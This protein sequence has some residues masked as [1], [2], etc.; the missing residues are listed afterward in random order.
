MLVSS[1]A[2]G[3]A[4]QCGM[5]GMIQDD[6]GTQ[7]IG[8]FDDTMDF[9]L[10][11]S[12]SSCEVMEVPIAVW[13]VVPRKRYTKVFLDLEHPDFDDAAYLIRYPTGAWNIVKER[14]YKQKSM[15]FFLGDN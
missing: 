4:F 2:M 5:F 13:D 12:A 9:V 8:R 1:S 3:Q 7:F 11:E 6:Y 10:L 14:S 15:S